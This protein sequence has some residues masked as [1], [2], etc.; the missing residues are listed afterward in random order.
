[1]GVIREA[2]KKIQGAIKDAR[3]ALSHA[4]EVARFVMNMNDTTVPS[5]SIYVRDDIG[6][7]DL[8]N[9]ELK[10]EDRFMG[11][12]TGI[13]VPPAI[14][15]L[16]KVNVILYLHGDKVRVWGPTGTI[17]QYWSLPTFPLR[18]GLNASGQQYI[19]VAPTFG[20]SVHAEYGNLGT[21]IDQYLDDVMEQLRVF[22]PAALTPKKTPQIG[23]L[24]LAAHSGGFGP[25]TSIIKN[26]KKYKANVNEV[27]G[28]DIMYGNTAKSMLDVGVPVYAYFNDT[29]S[30]SRYLAGL[31][32]PK[33]TVMDP[34]ETF[35]QGGKVLSRRVKHDNLMQKY[36]L[37]RCQRIGSNGTNID[38]KKL[39]I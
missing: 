21:N 9:N 33:I 30:N 15:S 22:C 20:A 14:K 5:F 11:Q 36:W 4:P 28:F 37:D 13:Y 17:R 8:L 6:I 12:V 34:Q 39:K 7:Q 29:E 3:A 2:E 27:W 26:I 25:I 19:L 23:N 24:L 31:K 18:Q 16:D 1:M 38:D 35:T 32:N 10:K